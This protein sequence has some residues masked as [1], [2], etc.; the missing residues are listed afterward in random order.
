[1]KDVQSK[2]TQATVTKSQGPDYPA[3]AADKAKAERI[4]ASPANQALR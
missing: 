4:D 3:K 1:M 2:V